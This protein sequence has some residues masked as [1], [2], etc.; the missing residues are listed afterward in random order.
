MVPLFKSD[1]S[2][3]KSILTLN[4]PGSSEGSVSIFDLASTAKLTKLALVEDSLTGFLKAQQQCS[5]L[6][7]QLLFGLRLNICSDLSAEV[8]KKGDLTQHKVII[9][10]RNSAGCRLL[11]ELYSVAFTEGNGRLDLSTLEKMWSEDNLKLT[12]PFYDSFIFNNLLRFKSCL[13]DFS[14]CSPLFFLED[15]NLPMD[16]LVQEKVR[17][18]CSQHNYEASEAKSIYY[19]ER[20]DFPAYQTYKCICNRSSF[21][22]R[23]SLDKPNLDHCGS[24]EFCFESWQKKTRDKRGSF[25]I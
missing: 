9:F 13:M 25:Q 14:F 17:T 22:A 4:P 8:P 6:G 10:A 16:L 7:I 12:I 3:G 2:I 21:G 24:N 23:L 11:N 18:Y 5:N 15:N 20:K 1:F 19:S